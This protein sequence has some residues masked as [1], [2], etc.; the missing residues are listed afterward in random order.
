MDLDLIRARQ[1]NFIHTKKKKTTD[2]RPIMP[3]SIILGLHALPANL[4]PGFSL[5]ET[6]PISLYKTISTTQ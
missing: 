2:S 3:L 4:K 1:P 5:F 6:S